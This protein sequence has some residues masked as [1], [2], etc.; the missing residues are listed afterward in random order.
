MINPLRKAKLKWQCRRGMLELDLILLSFLERH[1]DSMSETQID[2]F[3]KLLHCTDPE[4]FAWLMGH[5]QP[6][7]QEFKDIVE[8][9]KLDDSI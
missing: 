3:D 8:F 6:E 2:S 4:L 9:I 5:E 7:A 1:V